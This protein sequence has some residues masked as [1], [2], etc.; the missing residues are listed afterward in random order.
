M[1]KFVK[2]ALLTGAAISA[3]T[4]PAVVAQAQ[5]VSEQ[6]AA[7]QVE[8]VIVT[9]RRREES[10]REVPVAVTAL[11]SE[12][13]ALTGAA[14]VTVLQQQT[15]NATVQVARGSNS[16]LISFIRGVGQQ[17][18]LW[19]FDPGVGLYVDDVYV[20]RPQGAVLDIFDIERIE[21][22]RGPQG[23]LYGRNTIGGAIKYVTSR[24][25]PE[26]EL[27]LRGAV[28]SDGQLDMIASGSLPVGDY[29]RI[30][31]AVASYNR[32][33]FGQNLTTGA[34]HYDKDVT[35]ARVSA[36]LAPTSNLFFRFAWDRV[37]DNSNA[38]HGHREVAGAA[39]GAD[40]LPGI[41]DTRSGLGDDN[42][43]ETEGLSLTAE[44]TINDMLTFKSI[45]ARRDGY[46]DTV[47]DFDGT[48]SPTLD[49]PAYYADDQFTQEFQ[50]LF[51]GARWQGVAGVYYLDSHA[52]GA[53][54]TVLGN[55]GVSIG[56]GG[57]VDTESYAVFADFNFDLSDR[58]RVAVGA[59]Y[60]EDDKTGFVN[61]ATYLGAGQ[62]PLTGGPAATPLVQNTLYTNSRSFS[63]FTPRISVSYDLNDDL[64]GYA[65]F[66]QGFKSGGFDMRG[67][68]LATPDTVDGYDP[69]TVDSYELGLKGYAF[70]R[71][72]TFSSALFY[73]DYQDQQVTTQVPTATGI[74]SFVDNVGA[75]T[76]YGAEFEGSLWLTDFLT[77]N[78]AVGYL[79]AEFEEF[80]RYNL[81]TMQ[82]EDISDLVVV[83]NSPRWSGYLGVTWT[84]DLL[85]GQLAITPSV[86]YRDD[87][88][89]FEFPNPILDQEAYALVDL[90]VVWTTPDQRWQLALHG[91]NLTDEEY[92]T[93]GYNFP[94]ALF[95]NSISAFYGPP[96]TWTAALQM[97]F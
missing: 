45:T 70:D 17:D 53:F 31:G 52:E 74:A 75:S 18:P 20:A 42:Y 51:N 2:S 32:D 43:V 57:F 25:A 16:T 9:A 90:S 46:T 4:A 55:L 71:R 95:D 91:K 69:E 65:A 19:G 67:D 59:R 40:V 28:G 97:R 48:P 13:L 47:I 33:G 78:F 34:D 6:P 44:W 58:L 87:F 88:S 5:E 86:S 39:P 7:T 79:R 80:I 35:A 27:M 8:E 96:R 10:L 21:V 15:P 85:D 93:G 29:L 63:E 76:I 60:T 14:D 41:Y 56:T 3:L 11:S 82:Y 64:T 26:P 54:D 50:L 72:L 68:A 77:A 37:E 89:Q 62:T 12:R 23:T 81:T 49:I 30:G 94:G 73:S 38:R 36:E 84:N 22:L 66:S 24:L 83:Q 1:N 61:R 92:R